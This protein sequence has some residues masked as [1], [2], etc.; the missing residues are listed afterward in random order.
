MGGVDEDAGVFETVACL[1]RV[2]VQEGGEVV[3]A[4]FDEVRGLEG[5]GDLA[6][7]GGGRVV[8]IVGAGGVGVEVDVV[9]ESVQTGVRE[10]RGHGFDEEVEFVVDVGGYHG[11]GDVCVVGGVEGGERDVFAEGDGGEEGAEEFD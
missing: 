7:L 10:V 6:G 9:E 2:C 3:L 1:G 4:P 11:G 8:V 5:E